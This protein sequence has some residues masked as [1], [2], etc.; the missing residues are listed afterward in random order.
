M[1]KEILK[2]IE[3]ISILLVTYQRLHFLKHTVKKIYE[4]TLYPYELIVIDNNSTD[5]TRGWLK[6]AKINGFV[7]DYITLPENKGLAYGLSEGFKKVKSEYFITTQ[8]DVVP[9]DLRPCWLERMLHIAKKN[10]DYGGI[11]MRIQRVRHREIDEH[12]ELYESP[13]SLASFLRI[14]KKNDIEEIGGFGARKHWESVS[15]MRRMKPLKKKL[16]V[17]TKLYCDHIGFMPDNKGFPAGFTNYK[18]YAKERVTQGRDQPYPRIDP[19]TLI[20][21]EIRTPRDTKEQTKR[22]AYWDYWGMDGRQTHCQSEDQKMLAKYA[23]KGHGIEV[24]CGVVKSHPNAIGVDIFPYKTVDILTNGNDL[25]MFKDEELDFVIA[26]HV[27][28]HFPNTKK[29]LKEWYRILKKGGIMGIA[30]P[31]GGAR[32]DSIRGSHKVA[33][34]KEVL[35][36]IFKSILK[37]KILRL[38]D[39]PNKKKEH[40]SILL[41]AKK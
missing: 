27:I 4:R 3:P 7:H 41:I 32:P 16:G 33:L 23:N 15:F 24:G 25:W 28:E 30:C 34:T 29:V 1:P 8:D 35:N 18:T 21:L 14:Q 38:E 31:N 10:P 2:V 13:T 6:G 40:E 17:T 19:K 9:P 39:V 20:P 12:K 26:S 22:D 37:M 5:G 11:A 36:V